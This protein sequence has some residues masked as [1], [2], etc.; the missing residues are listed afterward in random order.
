[1]HERGGSVTVHIENFAVALQF[2]PQLAEGQVT[3]LGFED[4]FFHICHGYGQDNFAASHGHPFR[5]RRKW[6]SFGFGFGHGIGCH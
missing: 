3:Q 2:A 1:M 6:L 5:G 4:A